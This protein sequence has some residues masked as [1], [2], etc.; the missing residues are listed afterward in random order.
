MRLRPARDELRSPERLRLCN[1]ATR[2]SRSLTS[3][4]AYW[5]IATFRYAAEFGGYRGIADIQQA[6]S[7]ISPNAPA[8]VPWQR[9]P[10]HDSGQ[11]VVSARGCLT[12]SS[13]ALPLEPKQGKAAATRDVRFALH[14]LPPN[15]R[16]PPC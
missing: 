6:L 16:R 7:E 10:G 11:G 15:P 8:A 3:N 1:E 2:R 5:H 12:K 14:F 9:P 4:L 13:V